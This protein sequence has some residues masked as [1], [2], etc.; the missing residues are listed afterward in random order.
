MFVL[1]LGRRVFLWFN[2]LALLERRDIVIIQISIGYSSFFH[3]NC[4]D[5]FNRRLILRLLETLILNILFELVKFL[6][7]I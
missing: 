7:E 6:G 1:F 4:W 3:L 2:F 5:L